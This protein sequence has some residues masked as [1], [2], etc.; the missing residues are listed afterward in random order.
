MPIPLHIVLLAATA[1]ADPTF[2][3]TVNLS[4]LHFARNSNEASIGDHVDLARLRARLDD[5][6]SWGILKGHM[7]LA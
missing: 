1:R 7:D 5:S 6:I 3:R 2:L 4:S